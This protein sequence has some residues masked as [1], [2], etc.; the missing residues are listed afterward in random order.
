MKIRNTIGIL[1]VALLAASC[2]KSLSVPANLASKKLFDAW[3]EVNAPNAPATE[4]GC[5]ILSDEPGTGKLVSD[6]DTHPF[7]YLE[8]T[9]SDLDGNIASTTDEQ[10]ARRLGTYAAKTYYGP[11]AL[12][13]AHSDS[14][15]RFAICP[16]LDDA[17][18]TMRVGGRRKVAIPGWLTG[19]VHYADPDDYYLNETGSHLVYD[20]RVV[21]AVYDLEARQIREIEDYVKANW[22]AADSLIFGYYYIRT[23]EPKNTDKWQP[24][25]VIYVNYTGRLLNGHVFDTNVK[26]T[27]KRYGIYN[28]KS[29]YEP[30]Y[31]T[32]LS[33]EY[34]EVK[35]TTSNTAVIP[36]FGYAM[37]TMHLGEKGTAVF[38]AGLGYG[39]SGSGTAIPAYAPLRFDFEIVRKKE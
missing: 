5:R 8:Y 21:D 3:I 36:G 4:L 29:T 32:S 13:R 1:A 27:A 11:V 10:V 31:V 34:T 39:N 26:D 15:G 35:M 22:H 25:D 6:P 20:V 33:G 37:T 16:G 30:L 9:V 24:N 38:Y 28:A 7:V 19:T 17:I 12:D 2:A 23:Q 14:Y 18:S